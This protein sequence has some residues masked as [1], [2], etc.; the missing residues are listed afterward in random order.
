[1]HTVFSPAWGDVV[2][3]TNSITATAAVILP[4]QSDELVMTNT[5]LTAVVYV[6]VTPYLDEA[7]PPAGTAPTTSTGFPVLTNS[8]LRVHVGAGNKVVRTI[9][10]AADGLIILSPGNGL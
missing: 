10:S 6:T 5:S 8:Q 1:M 3:V 9:A 7:S 4:P 2:P